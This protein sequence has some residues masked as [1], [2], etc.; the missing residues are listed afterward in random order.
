[1]SI[2]SKIRKFTYVKLCAKVHKQLLELLGIWVYPAYWHYKLKGRVESPDF[3][4]IYFTAR[5]H[6]GAG[7]GHQITNWIAGYCWAKHFGLTFAHLPFSSKAWDDFLGFG[8]EETQVATL[9][10]NGWK[11]RRIPLFD[12]DDANSVELAKNIISTYS[13]TKTIILCEQDQSYRYIYDVMGDLKT[14]FRNA[15]T[16]DHDRL[17]YEPSHFNVAIHVRRGDIM[18]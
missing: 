12:E 13:G 3:S 18:A 15:H 6:I 5:P 8:Q 2:I 4:Y 14:K 1:M 10:K 17:T 11:V 16:N 9:R 7:I